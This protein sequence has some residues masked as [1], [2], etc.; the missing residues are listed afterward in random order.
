MRTLSL[1]LATLAIAGCA[2]SPVGKINCP[3]IV[4]GSLPQI[5]NHELASLTPQ[6]RS[7]LLEREAVLVDVISQYE[8]AWDEICH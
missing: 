3:A 2:I 8:A 7:Q 6:T 4:W 1:I 5:P